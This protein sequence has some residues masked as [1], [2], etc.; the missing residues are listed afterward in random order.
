MEKRSRSIA[1][2]FVLLIYAYI[3]TIICTTLKIAD[4]NLCPRPVRSNSG[5]QTKFIQECCPDYVKQNGKCQACSAGKFGKDCS[6]LCLPNSHG[7]Q[8]KEPCNC[9]N[10]K[11]CDPVHGCICNTGFTGSNCSN[12]CP[13]GT[14]GV[15]CVE[16]CLCAHDSN[17]D[18]VTGDCLCLAGW[19]GIHCTKECPPETY[20]VNCKE[21]CFCAG[22]AKCD[23]VTGDCLCT[24]GQF[25]EYCT[26]E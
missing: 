11:I 9:I 21:E 22:G 18:P 20:G 10:N 8:C 15:N 17:C 16:E 6:Q 3:E 24:A 14:Y 1:N 7:V 26:K 25:G 2:V 13:P 4:Q 19:F 23:H 5:T 12:A